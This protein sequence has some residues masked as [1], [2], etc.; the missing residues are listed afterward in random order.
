MKQYLL[1]TYSVDGEVP[2]S[3]TSAEE[4]KQFMERVAALEAEMDATGAFVFGGGLT[5][6]DAA[7]VLHR[8]AGEPAVTDG[9]TVA[10]REQI[11]GF[12]ILNAEDLD[13]ALAWGRKVVAATNHS[14]E[15]RAFFA[16]GRVIDSMPSAEDA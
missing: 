9:P 3:P 10:S 8:G 5:G 16:T 15:L 12:Y 4:G 6:P 2:G 11:A 1:S 13:D 7:K 14:I